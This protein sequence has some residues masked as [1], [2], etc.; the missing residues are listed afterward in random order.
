MISVTKDRCQDSKR[1]RM[2][3]NGADGDSGRLDRW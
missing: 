3:K 1:S 2:I